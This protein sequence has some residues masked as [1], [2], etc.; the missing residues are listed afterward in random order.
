MEGA[1][2]INYSNIFLNYYHM[3]DTACDPRI[4]EHSLIYVYSGEIVLSENGKVIRVKE[5][6][7]A[8]IRRDHLLRMDKHGSDA[9]G[10]YQS[11]VLQFSRTF[12]MDYYRK[13]DK[14]ELPRE[15]K[16]SKISVM[17]IPSRP[18]VVS[19]FESI[20][21]YFRTEEE[22]D[23]EWLRMKVNEGLYVVLKTA[24]HVYASLFD[25]SE[26]WKIDL[27]GFMEANYMYEFSQEDLALYTG[28]SLSTLKRDFKK[29]SDLSPQKWLIQKRLEAA[30]DR[31]INQKGK[32]KDIC[33]DVGFKNL[34]HFSKAYK[35]VYGVS[36][37]D[38]YRRGMQ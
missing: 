34:A 25:F 20:R 31:I 32:I 17:K 11:I 1:R 13:C 3:G 29:I 5:G 10:V 24:S 30:H 4:K 28:R 16:R 19:L 8:F 12:L 23:K 14:S 38:S 26:Y 9:D 35:S 37:T 18:D 22:P 7:C 21:P 36:P 15:V 6:E 27:L 2:T 33:V